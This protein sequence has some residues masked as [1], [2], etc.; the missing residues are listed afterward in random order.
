MNNNNQIIDRDNKNNNFMIYENVKEELKQLLRLYQF[1]KT[2]VLDKELY[3]ESI[4]TCHDKYQHQLG[5][6]D[7]LYWENKYKFNLFKFNLKKLQYKI[8]TNN[9]NITIVKKYKNYQMI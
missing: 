4:Q 9:Q 3:L 1:Q 7:L 5:G 8:Q 6:L 2:K